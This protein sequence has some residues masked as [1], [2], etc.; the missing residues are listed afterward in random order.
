MKK[1][2]IDSLNVLSNV[3][4]GVTISGRDNIFRMRDAFFVLDGMVKYVT[5][6]PDETEETE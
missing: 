1:E 6:L 2:F 5:N 3:L 4:S